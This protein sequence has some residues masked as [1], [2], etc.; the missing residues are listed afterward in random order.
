M[1]TASGSL[2]LEAMSVCDKELVRCSSA[3]ASRRASFSP[4]NSVEAVL[5]RIDCSVLT[6]SVA[7]GFRKSVLRISS[8]TACFVYVFSVAGSSNNS[9]T[10]ANSPVGTPT[11]PLSVS[12]SRRIGI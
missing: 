10:T 12:A 4:S 2:S 11:S 8:V 6:P 5:G 1:T 9:S 7:H 3:N